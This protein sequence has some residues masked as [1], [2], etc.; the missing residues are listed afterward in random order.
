[1]HGGKMRL[2]KYA[3]LFA[4][5]FILGIAA[6]IHAREDVSSYAI[7]FTIFIFLFIVTF[8]TGNLVFIWL[9][10]ICSFI[11]IISNAFYIVVF[12]LDAAKTP[13]LFVLKIP[14]PIFAVVY[15]IVCVNW[16]RALLY[17]EEVEEYFESLYDGAE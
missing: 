12:I 1:M 9:N 3:T 2:I 17:D 11:A 13:P 6:D 5:H 7:S 16:I 4:A 14:T 10:I 15:I 8:K